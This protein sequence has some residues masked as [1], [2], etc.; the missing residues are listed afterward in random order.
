MSTPDQSYEFL[1]AAGL[2]LAVMAVVAC[3]WLATALR[4]VRRA[5]T[6]VIG[7]ENRDIVAHAEQLQREF[8]ALRDWL[9]EATGRLDKRMKVAEDRLDCAVAHR[10]IVRYDAFGEM[11]GRQSSTIALLDEHRSGVVLSAIRSRNHSHLYVKQLVAGES[12]IELSPEERQAVEA[13]VAKPPAIER[14][15]QDAPAPDPKAPAS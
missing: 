13:A 12:D 4:R 5:Q 3:I 6:T 11:S 10:A 15:V 2:A 1:A 7:D 9:D 14:S 8:T